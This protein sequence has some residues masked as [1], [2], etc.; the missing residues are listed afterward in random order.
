MKKPNRTLS[1]KRVWIWMPSSSNNRRVGKKTRHCAPIWNGRRSKLTSSR[2]RD[3]AAQNSWIANWPTSRRSCRKSTAT[4]R[5]GKLVLIRH[6]HCVTKMNTNRR[7]TVQQKP[8][9]TIKFTGLCRTRISNILPLSKKLVRA[10]AKKSSTWYRK[11][12]S[13]STSSSLA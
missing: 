3:K 5:P 12:K 11:T 7:F 4:D 1:V 6:W 10:N 9:I 13:A 8:T 2:I